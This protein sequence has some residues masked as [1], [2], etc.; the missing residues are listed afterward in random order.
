MKKL[1]KLA[2]LTIIC[3]SLLSSYNA[4]AETSKLYPFVA[5]DYTKPELKLTQMN[6]SFDISY[7]PKLSF[8]LAKDFQLDNNWQ[9][10]S[11]ISISYL[12]A[13]VHKIDIDHQI[14]S[15]N[16]KEL[17]LWTSVKLKRNNLFEH[18]TPFVKI[19]AGLID[20]EYNDQVTNINAKHAAFKATTGLEFNIS[21]SST[22]SLGVGYSNFDDLTIPSQ[23]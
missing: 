5:I 20:A 11:N 14:Q 12:N 19:S 17:G 16:Y 3:L 10:T 2:S 4:L 9:L 15:V 22:I 7:A 18:V 21:K 13:S 6:N 1:N 8:G 23:E